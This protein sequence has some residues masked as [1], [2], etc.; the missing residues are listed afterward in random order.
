MHWYDKLGNRVDLSWPEGSGPGPGL[1]DESKVRF[2]ALS[3]QDGYFIPVRTGI[4]DAYIFWDLFTDMAGW[5]EK[6]F[7]TMFAR[8]DTAWPPYGGEPPGWRDDR[9]L[10]RIYYTYHP[11]LALADVREAIWDYLR[12][13]RVDLAYKM[14]L[15]LR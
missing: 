3:R 14:G 8:I 7:S 1:F 12:K 13:C 6:H 9:S 4:D 2:W 11:E 5:L 10:A 15:M